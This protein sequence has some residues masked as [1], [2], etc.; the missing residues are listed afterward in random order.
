M[1]P[2]SGIRRFPVLHSGFLQTV[3]RPSALAFGEWFDYGFP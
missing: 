1:I 3:G 2:L